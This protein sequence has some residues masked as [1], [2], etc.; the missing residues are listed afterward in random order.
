VS[1]G[2]EDENA[3]LKRLPAKLMPNEAVLHDLLGKMMVPTAKREAV[4]HLRS[5]FEMNERRAC[6]EIGVDRTTVR[7][8]S[9][10][11]SRKLM[12][13]SAR[14]R[15]NEVVFRS[16]AFVRPVPTGREPRGSFAINHVSEKGLG[17]ASETDP[18]QGNRRESANFGERRFQCA[19]A[20]DFGHKQLDNGRRSISAA[21]WRRMPGRAT[22]E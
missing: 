16:H 7:Y 6:T 18:T 13:T 17:C 2:L 22:P 15:S 4:A 20:G 21:R 19:L 8:C 9:I 14:P 1:E 12:G 3:R 11:L 10:P 5:E